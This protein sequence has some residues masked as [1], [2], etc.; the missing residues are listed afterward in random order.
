VILIY[1]FAL[2]VFEI[3]CVFARL[4]FRYFFVSRKEEEIFVPLLFKNVFNIF[5]ASCKNAFDLYPPP[6]I[7]PVRIFGWIFDLFYFGTWDK[8]EKK[9]SVQC[10]PPMT[11]LWKQEKKFHFNFPFFELMEFDLFFNFFKRDLFCIIT[12]LHIVCLF[13]PDIRESNDRN[14]IYLIFKFKLQSPQ[15]N[16]FLSSSFQYAVNILRLTRCYQ[17]FVSLFTSIEFI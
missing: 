17:R 12:M 3:W 6:L 11:W 9:Y 14:S 7:P 4:L 1:N 8:E 10:T 15:R 5:A 2:S 13:I 16:I